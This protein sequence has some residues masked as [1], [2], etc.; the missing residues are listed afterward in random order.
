LKNQKKENYTLCDHYNHWPLSVDLT[1]LLKHKNKRELYTLWPLQPCF[2]FSTV[3]LDRQ[4]VVNGCSDHKVYNSLLF[5][6]FNSHVS[7][8]TWLLKHKNKRELYTLWSLPPLTTICRSN[9][10]VETQKLENYTLCDH[11]NHWPLSV[12][13]TWLLKHKNKSELYTLWSLQSLTTICRSNMIV[14]TQK[15]KKIIHVVITT[16]IDHYMSI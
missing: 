7:D 13:L 6:C 5:L 4:I 1:W 10:T 15:Q 16:T 9:M 2:C 14:E 12:D 3:M 11:Y 8:L